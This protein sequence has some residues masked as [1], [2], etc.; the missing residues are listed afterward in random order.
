[1]KFLCLILLI[2]L[3]LSACSRPAESRTFALSVMLDK[4]FR[5]FP[6]N[7]VQL[8]S[9]SETKFSQE[10]DR[11]ESCSILKWKTL[12]EG[13]YKLTISTTFYTDVIKIIPLFRDQTANI[14]YPFPV[15]KSDSFTLAELENADTIQFTFSSSGCF[16]HSLE[17]YLI[18]KIKNSTHRD[19]HYVSEG[20]LT[21]ASSPKPHFRSAT[22]VDSI[23]SIQ[24]KCLERKKNHP[25]LLSTE[26]RTV[27]ILANHKL[28]S[29]EFDP[30]ATLETKGLTNN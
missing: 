25:L 18:T 15:Q 17:K 23:F 3:T 29:L 22:I 26:S 10:P 16:H 6:C 4:N 27:F 9:F 20:T 30:L 8:S 5:Q 12:P 21:E 24:A 19:V 13:L 11:N 14:Q 1:M 28:F 7:N 2:S